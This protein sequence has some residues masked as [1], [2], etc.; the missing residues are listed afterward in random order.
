[1]KNDN[2]VYQVLVAGSVLAKSETAADLVAGK[3][4]FVDVSTSA[5][6]DKTDSSTVK[7]LQVMSMGL[8]GSMIVAPTINVSRLNSVTKKA[9]SAG[10]SAKVTITLPAIGT[11]T[12]A[13]IESNEEIGVTF[14]IEAGDSYQH[15]GTNQIRKHFYVLA[16]TSKTA[17][18]TTL[19]AAINADEESTV[20]GGFIL[21]TVSSNVVTVTFA[22]NNDDQSIPLVGKIASAV[23]SHSSIVVDNNLTGTLTPAFAFAQGTGKYIQRLE[24]E[25][26]PYSGKGQ[27]GDYRY[28][29]DNPEFVN[30]T[31]DAVASSNYDLYILN[32]D[33]E[34]AQNSG[35]N[36]NFEVMIAAVASSATSTAINDLLYNVVSGKKIGLSEPEAEA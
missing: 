26:F 36:D 32:Y 7:E 28:L 12:N 8:D 6:V 27:L 4:G 3:T 31:P 1:M 14:A 33:L 35:Y 16:G 22:F 2:N 10:V 29:P 5:A 9:Y 19:A 20:N 11:D 24:K 25:A 23:V 17:T 30:F 15:M 18:A 13:V 34:Y 21:A